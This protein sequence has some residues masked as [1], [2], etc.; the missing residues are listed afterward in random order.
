MDAFVTL[1]MLLLL[2]LR[3]LVPLVILFALGTWI[4]RR[5]TYS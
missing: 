2:L 4:M 3:I 5:Y 1:V